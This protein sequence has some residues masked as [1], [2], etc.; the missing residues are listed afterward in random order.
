MSGLIV[1]S[2]NVLL[3]G[4]FAAAKTVGNQEVEIT[5]LVQDSTRLSGSILK[6]AEQEASRIFRA[7]G[8]SIAWVNCSVGSNRVD[9]EC[10]RVPGPTQFVLHI[11]ATGKTSS[12]LVFGLAFLDENGAGKYS[13]VFLDRIEAAHRTFGTDT[14]RLLGTIVA[15][16][17]GHLLL[18]N[19]A[20]SYAGVMAPVW[21]GEVLQREAMGFLLFTH[22]QALLMKRRLAD[23]NV[24]AIH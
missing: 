8:I 15:H 4:N 20:H 3:W 13:D 21:R 17:L 5:V 19:H 10:Y 23:G 9:E 14:S 24:A 18:G 11:V 2:L 12:D 6:E 16:E 22:D 7:A 1:A